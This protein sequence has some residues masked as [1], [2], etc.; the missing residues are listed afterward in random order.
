MSEKGSFLQTKPGLEQR[1]TPKMK[2]QIN[3]TMK[4]HLLRGAFCLLLLMLMAVCVIPFALGQRATTKQSA[5]A[6]PLLLGL[7]P[8]AGIVLTA[9]TRRAGPGL[10]QA[11]SSPHAII[12]PRRCWPTARC[13]SRGDITATGDLSSAELYDPASETWTTTG[14]LNTAR[15]LTRRRCCPTA[16]CSWQED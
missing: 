12:T 2:K 1:T 8:V 7:A 15:G 13:W 14:S 16:R 11:A 6:D 5:V 4:A 9:T 3:P 10:Q